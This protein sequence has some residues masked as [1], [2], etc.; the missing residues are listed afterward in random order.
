MLK[1]SVKAYR[2]S[3]PVFTF[4]CAY[5]TAEGHYVGDEFYFELSWEKRANTGWSTFMYETKRY[6]HSNGF[7]IKTSEEE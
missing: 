5:A 3:N 7:K 4:D 6:Y 2:S 1:L